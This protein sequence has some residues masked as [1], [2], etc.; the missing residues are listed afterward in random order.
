MRCQPRH[1]SEQ[2]A[3]S[4]SAQ[5]A[6][7]VTPPVVVPTVGA[8]VEIMAGRIDRL[9]E[10]SV[11]VV[12]L[13]GIPVRPTNTRPYGDGHVYSGGVRDPRSR[14]AIDA[15]YP[16]VILDQVEWG[17]EAII[18]GTITYRPDPHG[19]IRPRFNVDAVE[20][21]G[22]HRV[23][24]KA[25]L[26]E[27]WA[28]AIARPK[29]DLGPL[30]DLP[31]PAIAVVTGA[32]SVAFDDVLGQLDGL[33]DLVELRRLDAPLT[34]PEAVAQTVRSASD[35]NLV[36]LARGG[37]AG[38][39]ELDADALIEAVASSVTPVAVAVG[40]ETDRLVLARV[41][42]AGFATPTAFGA[43]LR[44]RLE[45]R[46]AVVRQDEA[47]RELARARDLL[48]EV[49][50]LGAKNDVLVKRVESLGADVGRLTKSLR[51]SEAQVLELGKA[52]ADWQGR[53][54]ALAVGL[55]QAAES[56]Q[57]VADELAAIKVGREAAEGR[58]REAAQ[59]M[60]S[61]QGQNESLTARVNAV[62]EER[63][64]AEQEVRKTAAEASGAAAE[65][66]VLREANRALRERLEAAE[67]IP[68]IRPSRWQAAA[69]VLLVIAG[70]I[71]AAVVALA[72]LR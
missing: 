68:A 58:L 40:H 13:R 53:S 15:R 21:V 51:A 37:G 6:C 56:R 67:A 54:S 57:A 11:N 48:K 38:V 36:V 52:S 31:R 17:A 5:S 70:M 20:R 12:R 18:A 69:P 19:V 29:R 28:E 33:E 22:D 14:V 62:E 47:A 25:D 71:L 23:S 26:T 34:A 55:K 42:D 59:T 4:A 61:L 10:A 39:H 35:A 64:R 24:T 3:M 72:L 1:R 45:A 63:K 32:G 49:S 44:R 66:E 41:A 27:K 30:L 60:A 46:R 43:W 65:A 50:E 16:A 9:H 2:P 8:F 7:A